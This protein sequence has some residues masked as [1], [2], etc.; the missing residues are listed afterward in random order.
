MILNK[1]YRKIPAEIIMEFAKKLRFEMKKMREYE[2]ILINQEKLINIYISK[3]YRDYE[4][5]SKALA[6][7]HTI[8]V[9]FDDF[10][11]KFKEKIKEKVKEI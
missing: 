8:K 3:S 7:G 9:F 5:S 6:S 10:N 1:W 4:L 2:A 11:E